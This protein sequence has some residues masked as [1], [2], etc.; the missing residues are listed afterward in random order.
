M[1]GKKRGRRGGGVNYGKL[2]RLPGEK[3]EVMAYKLLLIDFFLQFPLFYEKT[4]E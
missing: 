1:E 4:Q 2:K 3:I